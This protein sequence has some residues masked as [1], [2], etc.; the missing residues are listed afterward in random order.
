MDAGRR[1]AVVVTR[2]FR[3]YGGRSPDPR[4]PGDARVAVSFVVNVEE[5]AELT[6]SAGDERNEKAH[7]IIEEVVGVP[8]PCMETHYEYGTRAGYWRIADTLERGAIP[9]T[10]NACGRAVE[11]SPWLAQDAVRRG[12]EVSAHGYRWERHA[13]LTEAEE[14]AIIAKTVQAITAAAGTR[15]VGWHT[16]SAPSPNTR[17]LLLAHGGFLYDSDA[18]SD[19]LP[20]FVAVE[21]RSHLVIPY[22]FDTNDMQFH[23]AA[24]RFR[25]GGDFAEYVIDAFDTLWREGASSP[26]MLSVGLHLRIIG[27]PGRI[28]G[29]ERVVAHMRDKGSVW[30]ARRDA[31][32]RH[33]LEHFGERP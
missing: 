27:R 16:R 25:T 21:G 33:W 29:L 1:G 14:R 20:F 24:Q 5:G 30:F 8:D 22:C 4:W 6:L 12:H 26:K 18:Y 10:M 13:E 11:V 2:D 15:P 7:E 9:A 31:I 19:D 28:G 3:G 17:R 23:S 32:A